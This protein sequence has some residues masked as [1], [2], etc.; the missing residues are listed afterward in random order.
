MVC[1]SV[2]EF[3]RKMAFNRTF[4]AIPKH[5]YFNCATQSSVDS[6]TAGV[7]ATAT[8]FESRTQPLVTDIGQFVFNLARLS[9]TGER[10]FPVLQAMIQTNQPDPMRTAYT[11]ALNLSVAARIESNG[12]LDAVT[13]QRSLR[14]A[15]RDATGTTYLE[16]LVSV[17][18]PGLNTS[19]AVS[20]ALTAAII[21]AAPT[22]P[23][24]TQTVCST[25]T[26]G[27]AEH[28][29]LT[30]GQP[31]PA[32]WSMGISPGTP[33]DCVFWGFPTPWSSSYIWGTNSNGVNGFLVMAPLPYAYPPI[34]Q[35][36]NV[37][38]PGF[39]QWK[40]QTAGLS[41]PRSPLDPRGVD[42]S[43][44]AYWAYD[45]EWFVDLF[46]SALQTTWFGTNGVVAQLGSVG[47]TVKSACPQVSYSDDT[48]KFSLKF[49]NPS[50]PTNNSYGETFS[51][52]VGQI[53]LNLMN[54]PGQYDQFGNAL[55]LLV[56]HAVALGSSSILTSTGPATGN[57][58]SPVGALVITTRMFPV[59]PEVYCNLCVCG[60]AGVV[61]SQ[62]TSGAGS[63]NIITDVV[64]NVSKASDWNNF[65][66]LF[67]PTLL[68]LSD[69]IGEGALSEIQI[70][71]GWR[72]L[73]TNEIHNVILNAGAAFS[74]KCLFL[75]R[76]QVV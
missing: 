61:P 31:L 47:Y 17:F 68:R 39:I 46:N 20:A 73:A 48:D 67:S 29:T 24:L 26:I 1:E 18:G 6:I 41:L 23:Y 25:A 2:A 7:E 34:T 51:M 22:D 50:A 35:M 58:W 45:V 55:N 37:S 66:T 30:C 36:F 28:F 71:I 52:S 11:F 13:K 75:Q 12:V 49:S 64:P 42:L 38:V 72:N 65:P 43:N 62:Q 69:M 15:M 16:C 32:G 9:L 56:S 27:A 33:D 74:A 19:A 44:P 54:W 76:G 70:S 53:L 57:L 63:A 4:S 8:F 3:E 5:L 14:V 21:A 60:S 10:N 40:S 59:R